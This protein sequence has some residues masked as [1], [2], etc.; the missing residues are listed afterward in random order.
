[1]K[2]RRRSSPRGGGWRR[3]CDRASKSAWALRVVVGPKGITQPPTRS[4]AEAT[5]LSA[6]WKTY[7]WPRSI[8]ILWCVHLCAGKRWAIYASGTPGIPR[9]FL[10]ASLGNTAALRSFVRSFLPSFIRFF[11]SSFIRLHHRVQCLLRVVSFS[12][13]LALVS[14]RRA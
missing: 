11:V 8:F 3:G 14:S 7:F 9:D 2:W 12:F 13:F 1:M 6:G 5:I 10:C 4:T